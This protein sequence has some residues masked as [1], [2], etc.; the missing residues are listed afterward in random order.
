MT[1]W[2]KEH[3]DLK[4]R[5]MLKTLKAKLQGTWNYYGLIGNCGRM[6]QLYEITCRTLYK[7]LNRRSQ[8]RSLK[9]AAFN[10]LLQRFAI[11]KP[12]IIE[13]QRTGMPCQREMSF[14]QRMVDEHLRR[15]FRRA[16]ARAS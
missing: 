6:N 8:R 14:C 4:L 15:I 3:R 5:R 16:Y 2:I 7:W 13:T 9:W 1:K 12:H 11:P 10:R